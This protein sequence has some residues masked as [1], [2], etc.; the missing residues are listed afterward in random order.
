M[1]RDPRRAAPDAVER[2]E[3]RIRGVITRQ[4]GERV[5]GQRRPRTH[6]GDRGEAGQYEPACAERSGL[7]NR[8]E[9][10]ND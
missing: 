1:R 6:R 5:L 9:A 7:E 10:M 2:I 8:T 3:L 4:R